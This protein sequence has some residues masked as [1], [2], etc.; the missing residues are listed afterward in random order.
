[1]PYPIANYV[2]FAN[3]YI[4]HQHFLANITK[5]T[6]PKYDHEAVKDPPWRGAMEG[7]ICALEKNITWVLQDLPRG[8][9]PIS[10]KWVY[11]VKYNSIGTIQ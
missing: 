8:K 6:D 2:I 7:E 4:S 10:Y 5:L 9:Q 3:F 11:H 1:M